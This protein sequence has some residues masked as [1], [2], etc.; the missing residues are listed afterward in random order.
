ME[1][2]I[3]MH[4]R[5]DSDSEVLHTQA[6]IPT[7]FRLH[8]ILQD[9]PWPRRINPHYEEIKGKSLAWCLTFPETNAKEE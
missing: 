2:Y 1:N 9:W 5:P 4:T 3:M 7:M 8:R 6:P